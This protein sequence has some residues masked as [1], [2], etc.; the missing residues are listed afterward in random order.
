MKSMANVEIVQKGKR[1][2]GYRNDEFVGRYDT[3]DD[4]QKAGKI[5]R[6]S[7]IWLPVSGKNPLAQWEM[8]VPLQWESIPQRQV[9][10]GDTR[11]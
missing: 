2:F 3:E 6:Y 8:G 7:D 9:H 5:A 1:W 11:T 10:Q 4:A